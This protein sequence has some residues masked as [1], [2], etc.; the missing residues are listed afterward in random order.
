MGAATPN[1]GATGRPLSAADLALFAELLT[2]LVRANMPLPEALK[3][4][5]REPESRRLRATLQALEREVTAGA[6]LAEALRRRGQFPELFSS[7]VEQGCATNDLYSVLLE[8]AREYRS[9]ERFQ[10]ALRTQ[11]LG[12]AATAVVF[13]VLLLGMVIWN[14]AAPFRELL[15]GLYVSPPLLT[16]L[17]FF[18]VDVLRD[19]L[20]L[21]VLVSAV[22]AMLAAGA[23]LWRC[24]AVRRRA[25]IC[26][27][28]DSVGYAAN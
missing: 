28:C 14:V 6:S 5:G 8:L 4:L 18:F 15:A 19:P 20:S 22:G 3:V 11:L 24:L 16:R 12:P 17:L 13:G 21:A 23:A 1:S 27:R 7:L 2:G 9:Q 25:R 26:A 10:E